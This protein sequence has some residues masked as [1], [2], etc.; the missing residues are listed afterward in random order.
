MKYSVNDSP[1]FKTKKSLKKYIK[2]QF[3]LNDVKD[4]IVYKDGEI[5]LYITDMKTLMAVLDSE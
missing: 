2:I 3:S 4:G 1:K 5:Q